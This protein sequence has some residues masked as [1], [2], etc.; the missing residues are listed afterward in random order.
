MGVE[1]GAHRST[2]AARRHFFEWS[3]SFLTWGGWH[4]FVA[5]ARARTCPCGSVAQRR[6]SLPSMRSACRCHRSRHRSRPRSS[7]GAVDAPR[8]RS[9]PPQYSARIL[10]ALS[11]SHPVGRDCR[12]RTP[13]ILPISD[14]ILFGVHPAESKPWWQNP[15]R[16]SAFCAAL[17]A[18]CAQPLPDNI[19]CSLP[20]WA[21]PLPSGCDILHDLPDPL[22][23][24]DETW[25]PLE[26]CIVGGA[27]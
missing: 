13:Q 7:H 14:G 8:S 26:N 9:R 10:T 19:H 22:P 18:C 20:L 4:M 12:A 2:N 3:P 27:Q 5:S 16:R 23:A 17:Q 25:G 6:P 24:W 1:A 15:A 11:R 21:P